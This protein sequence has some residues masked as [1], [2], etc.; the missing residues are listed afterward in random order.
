MATKST[1]IEVRNTD[2]QTFELTNTRL[3]DVSFNR[4]VTR[5]A[6][7]AFFRSRKLRDSVRC[8]FTNFNPS[9]YVIARYPEQGY[10]KFSIGCKYFGEE[11]TKTIRRWALAYKSTP[12]TS[13]RK[14]TKTKKRMKAAA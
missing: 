1:R 3:E 7:A 13:S 9:T 6:I 10:I 14:T 12:K 5:R 11:A 2:L 8:N 4:S